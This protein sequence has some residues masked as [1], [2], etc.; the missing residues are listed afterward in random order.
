[1]D[2]V[3]AGRC[4]CNLQLRSADTQNNPTTPSLMKRTKRDTVWQ[5]HL[6]AVCECGAWVGCLF[7]RL[8]LLGW[9]NASFLSFGQSFC[10]WPTL[11]D[12]A[13]HS[14][15]FCQSPLLTNEAGTRHTLLITLTSL[16]SFTAC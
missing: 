6:L 9:A 2:D 10:D 15:F 12:S 16:N 8:S 5:F 1:M 7:A 14:F 3:E 13:S 4:N 11:L